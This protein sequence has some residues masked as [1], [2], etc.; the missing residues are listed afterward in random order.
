MNDIFRAF[1]TVRIAGIEGVDRSLY[2]DLFDNVPD[3]LQPSWFGVG[4]FR[5]LVVLAVLG[6]ALFWVLR[7]MR[8][9]LKP[10][11][12]YLLGSDYVSGH[13]NAILW[14]E[15]ADKK[16]DVLVVFRS[17]AFKREYNDSIEGYPSAVVT[18][19]ELS[20]LGAIRSIY[21]IMVSVWRL[22]LFCRGQACTATLRDVCALP[23]RKVVYEAFFNRFPCQYFW[24]RDDYN[25][26]HAMRTV[27]MRNLGTT[28]LGFMHGISSITETTPQQR[29]VDFD[30]YYTQGWDQARKNW[31]ETWPTHMMVRP[32]GSVGL[33]RE[34]LHRL[35]S[36]APEDGVACFLS[37]CFYDDE[38]IETISCVA[39]AFPERQIFINIK[40]SDWTTAF[41]QK[42]NAAL[43]TFPKNVVVYDGLSYDLFFLCDT[44]LSVG[45]TLSAEAVQFHCHSFVLDY[46]STQWIFNPYRRYPGVCV[47]S[48]DELLKRMTAVRPEV[49]FSERPLW[50]SMIDLSGRVPWDEIRKDMGKPALDPPLTWRRPTLPTA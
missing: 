32:I 34:G 17:D 46:H 27:V 48:I 18:D 19:G 43:E 8:L 21:G 24:G 14:E 49:E 41:G 22:Y 11:K 5:F 35:S 29:H 42:L 44:V 26:G 15:V 6:R 45:S 39:I 1:P 12:S 37:P 3:G 36:G 20:I 28:S 23:Y 2:E 25:A 7:R 31:L 13:T 4:L 50:G 38:V 40:S 47:N 10:E 33:S 9:R 16:D 30:I